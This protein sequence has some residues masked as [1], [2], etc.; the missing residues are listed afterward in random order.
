MAERDR[1]A[2]GVHMGRVVGDAELAKHR[3]ALG[4]EGFVEFDDVDVADLEAEPLEQFFA[5]PAPGR[6]P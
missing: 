4:G 6:C 3:E 5:S 1:A 2:V